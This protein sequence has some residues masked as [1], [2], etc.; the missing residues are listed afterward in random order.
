MAGTLF[1]LGLNQQC[2]A[3]GRPL[4]DAPLYIYQANTS[5]PVNVYQDFELDILH[6]WP[7][8]TDSTGRLPAFWLPDGSI[9]EQNAEVIAKTMPRIAVSGRV[10]GKDSSRHA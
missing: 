8:R 2:D 9:A 5:T 7:L 4:L 1:S 10:V 3:Q 6:P